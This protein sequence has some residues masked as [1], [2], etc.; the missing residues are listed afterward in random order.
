[1]TLIDRANQ[2]GLTYISSWVPGGTQAGDEYIVKNP[3]RSDSKPGS[4]AIN[5]KTGKWGDFS[6][7]DF[8]GDPVSLY[9]YIFRSTLKGTNNAQIQSA[10]AK[11]I[12]RQ[13]S[14]EH[15]DEFKPTH[16]ID[17][18][19]SSFRQVHQGIPDP[20]EPDYSWHAKNSAKKP[21]KKDWD[22][23]NKKGHIV[24]KVARF[25]DKDGKVD[26]PFTLW[27]NGT[28]YKWRSKNLETNNPLYN[29]LGLIEK[30]ELPVLLTEGQKNAEDSRV[31]LINDFVTTTVYRSPEKTDLEPLRGREVYIW[32]DPDTAGRKKASKLKSILMDID[33]RIHLVHSPSGKKKWDI[34]DAI[35]EGWTRNQLVEHIE[36]FP[37]EGGTVKE[38]VYVDD[39]SF[40]IVGVSGD[41]IFIYS[42][43]LRMVQ[44]FKINAL[45]KGSLVTLMSINEWQ[46]HFSHDKGVNWDMAVDFILTQAESAPLYDESLVRGAGLWRDVGGKLVCS[47]GEGLIINNKLHDLMAI[48]SKYVYKRAKYKPY[49]S[50]NPMD[51]LESLKI[52]EIMELIN[53][54][55]KL[56]GVFLAGWLV[57]APFS[58]SLKWRPNIWLT[59]PSGSGKT[60]VH[61]QVVSRML[62]G[63]AEKV[64]AAG[65]TES[66]IRQRLNNCA[67]PVVIDEME[68]NDKRTKES[69]EALLAMARQ[70]SSGTSDV[71]I[72]KGSSDQ[73][74]ISFRINSMFFFASILASVVHNSDMDRIEI[75]E[76]KDPNM[77]KI[78]S[79]TVKF[80]NLQDKV[81]GILTSDY[82]ER[83]YSRILNNFDEVLKAIDVFVKISARI[84]G[85]Q[86]GGDQKGTLLAGCYMIGHDVAPT[87]QEAIE[88]SKQFDIKQARDNN[89]IKEDYELCM[90][91]ILQYQIEGVS[92]R[93]QSISLWLSEYKANPIENYDVATYLMNY[94]LKPKIL[95]AD[96]YLG[97][98]I[99]HFELSKVLRNS[100]WENTYSKLLKR[101]PDCIKGNEKLK[102]NQRYGI[103]NKTTIWIKLEGEDDQCPF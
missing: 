33:C 3:T 55:Y 31:I 37:L 80:E 86:R 2:V 17:D 67:S 65:S 85:T 100:P 94:G 4:F 71:E 90:E 7:Q 44:R 58:G 34:S 82:T 12:L 11:E 78:E 36:S 46:K 49:S 52:L 26:K 74:G 89:K 88:W 27:T 23:H 91:N 61:G 59:G 13:Y 18:Y 19:W 62:D 25:R 16:R 5:I 72:L 73:Q 9:A 87:E 21:F 54:N 66:G 97:I 56:D 77:E 39:L 8:G 64:A 83:F 30:E 93:K 81:N 70:S 63:F 41:Y 102:P 35:Q 98:A 92:R 47:T 43:R 75:L 28:E 60:W 101:H 1:M 15:F 51:N 20:P 53:F 68:S 6:S 32:V 57:L 69:I 40:K 38:E 96:L 103:I 79:R 29:L 76:M 10:A 50:D 45:G 84:L 99:N 48:D 24:F 22:F 14:N 42:S 95:N